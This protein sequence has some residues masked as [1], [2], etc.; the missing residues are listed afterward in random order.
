MSESTKSI[1]DVATHPDA[2]SSGSVRPDPETQN[3]ANNT[4]AAPAK[5]SFAK[6]VAIAILGGIPTLIVLAGLGGLAW[7]GHHHGWSLPKFSELTGSEKETD[8]LWCD[9]HGVPEADCISCNADLMP[10]G[11]LYGW[12]NEHGVHECVLHN[13]QLSQLNE[14]PK[15]NQEDLARASEAIAAYPRTKND[16]GCKMH[17]RRIQFPSIESVDHAGIDI[18]LVDRGPVVETIK[19]TGE[20]V[21]APTHVTHLS[22][23]SN[24]TIWQVEKNVGDKVRQGEILAL[25]DAVEVGRLKSRLLKALAQLELDTKTLE[26]VARLGGTVIPEKQIQEASAAKTE[27]EY[28]VESAVQA[29]SNLG[30]PIQLNELKGKSAAAVSSKLRFLGLPQ[31]IIESMNQTNGSAN[32]IP[33]LSPRDG[34]VVKRDAVAGEVID[35]GRPLFT[36]A[37]TSQMWLLLNVRLEEAE[38]IS[39][40]QKVVFKPDG[41]ER[42]TE[43]TITWVSTDVDSQTR[44]VRVRAELGNDDGRLRNET[45][46]A[47]DIVLREVD[48]AILV[49]NEAIHWEGCCHVAF[50]R[51]KDYFKEGSYKVF[52]TR[53]V[54]P[55]AV[56][57]DNTEIIAGL[58]PGEVVVT[59]GSGILRAELLKGNLGAG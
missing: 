29:L 13:P 43:G 7:W 6:R 53:S 22:S 56:M 50:V 38:R 8:A 17:L 42:E 25:V 1:S 33:I 46:G 58:L 21:Y 39:L 18:N 54:R 35:T 24:G 37:D 20:I 40:G 31:P 57:G 2:T 23:R 28:E 36:I 12:C 19:T 41:S 52:H 9:E 45:F 14:I 10:K 26:R 59:K 4:S 3:S 11:E 49:P 5:R 47:G 27:T 32:L 48:D 30:L 44:T 34:V 55:G 16:P 15:V 51:D